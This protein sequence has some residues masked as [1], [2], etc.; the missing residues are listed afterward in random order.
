MGGSTKTHGGCCKADRALS[1]HVSSL[2][3]KAEATSLDGLSVPQSKV[4]IWSQVVVDIWFVY[5]SICL[6]VCLSRPS[7]FLKSSANSTLTFLENSL[8]LSSHGLGGAHPTSNLRDG[9]MTL[10]KPII[11]SF[12]LTRIIGREWASDSMWLVRIRPE[13]FIQVRRERFLS[14]SM[15]QSGAKQENAV[16]RNGEI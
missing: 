15:P 14:A 8:T 5:F 2:T 9:H 16:L 7:L 4:S 12:P 10:P 3:H 1:N 6:F 13:N 11:S